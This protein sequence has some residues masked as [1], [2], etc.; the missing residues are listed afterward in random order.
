MQE[1]NVSVNNTI[2]TA[3]LSGS[4][5]SANATE[6]ENVLLDALNNLDYSNSYKASRMFILD[7]MNTYPSLKYFIDIHNYL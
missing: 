7:K 4:I 1:V 6:V 3:K 2:L 5:S